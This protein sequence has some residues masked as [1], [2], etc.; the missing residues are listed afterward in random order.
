MS[1]NCTRFCLATGNSACDSAI[2]AA[3]RFQC[4]VCIFLCQFSISLFLSAC[5]SLSLSLK[6]KDVLRRS[7]VC[8]GSKCHTGRSAKE[9]E[10]NCLPCALNDWEL[11]GGQFTCARPQTAAM[12]GSWVTALSSSKVAKMR[13]QVEFY[14]I[15]SNK[16]VEGCLIGHKVILFTV[17]F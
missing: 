3:F 14:W 2:S 1:C 6:C 9:R 5:R 17:F 10:R 11:A 12:S 16:Q 8:W 4:I 7:G 15:S 13:L